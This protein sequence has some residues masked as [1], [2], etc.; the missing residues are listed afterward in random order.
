[1][2]EETPDSLDT[3]EAVDSWDS[4]DTGD[5]AKGP[6]ALDGAARAEAIAFTEWRLKLRLLPLDALV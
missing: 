4:K 6:W 3:S 2:A 1:M 5:I